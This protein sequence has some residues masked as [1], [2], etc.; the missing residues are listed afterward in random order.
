MATNSSTN[1]SSS[2]NA[3]PWR[4]PFLSHLAQLAT[5]TFT[6]ATLHPAGRSEAPT[7]ALPCLPRAR[8]CVFRGLWAELPAN[9]HNAAPRNPAGVYESDLPVFT[10][11]ARSDKA[12]EVFDSAPAG[13]VEASGGATGGGGPVEA[14]FWVDAAGVRTQWRVRGHAW[15]LAGDV[16][17]E[18]S[19]GARKAREVLRSRMRRVG[20]RGEGEAEEKGWSFAREVTAH[21]GNLSP[22]MRG[23]FKAPPP[24]TPLA[25]H[26]AKG[27]AVG[28]RLDDLEDETARRNFRVVV[29]VPDEVDQVDLSDELRPRRWLYVYRGVGGESKLPGGEIIGEWEKVEVWP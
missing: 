23:S 9:P 14:V 27:E 18:A 1:S 12:T 6:L 22:L 7:P 16:D 29:I 2:T 10:T 13:D 11:D 4:A 26:T 25:Y 5:A 3:A 8:T 15:V 17:D 28:Q 24:G 19:E 21:F 20:G